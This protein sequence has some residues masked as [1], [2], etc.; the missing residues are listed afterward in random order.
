MD[1]DRIEGRI[2]EEKG[3][4]AELAGLTTRKRK[5]VIQGKLQ[6]IGGRIQAAF[7]NLRKNIDKSK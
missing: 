2:D 5:M 4:A 1:N 3:T 6:S 7:G